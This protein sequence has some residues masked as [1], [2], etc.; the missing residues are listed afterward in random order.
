MEVAK[1]RERMLPSEPPG[2]SSPADAL[3]SA[4]ETDYRLLTSR[5]GGERFAVSKATK[6][7]VIC[8][9]SDRKRIH[10]FSPP[11]EG[12]RVLPPGSAPLLA[13]GG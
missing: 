9:R 12:R 11:E 13:P 6:R 4:S 8:H 3:T 7:M 1:G 2:G 10:T 5:T